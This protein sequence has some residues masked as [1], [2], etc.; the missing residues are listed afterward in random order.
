MDRRD[1]RKLRL[2]R[3]TV[4]LLQDAELR[5]VTSGEI[6]GVPGVKRHMD[7]HAIYESWLCPGDTRT[8]QPG[9]LLL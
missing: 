6:Q 2:N 4:R 9:G 8:C 3:E 1:Q 5:R 7:R